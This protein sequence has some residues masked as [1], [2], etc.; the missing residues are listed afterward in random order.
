MAILSVKIAELVAK[1][2]HPP[3]PPPRD[4]RADRNRGRPEV[5]RPKGQ[6]V[7]K[8][9]GAQGKENADLQESL[10]EGLEGIV[11][12]AEAQQKEAELREGLLG[13]HAYEKPVEDENSQREDKA[14]NEDA[15]HDAQR[16]KAKEAAVKGQEK[17]QGAGNKKF[18]DQAKIRKDGFEQKAE[19]AHAKTKIDAP[20]MAGAPLLPKFQGGA[21]H[22]LNNAREPGGYFQE[23]GEGSGGAGG[24][25]E[26]QGDPELAA[27][28]EEAIR[29]LFGVRGIHRIGPGLSAEGEPVV[30]ISTTRGFSESSMRAV[31]ET[32][33]RFKTL[34][35]LPYEL[36]PLRRDAR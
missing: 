3:R 27:A 24:A 36:L 31:P 32:V 8:A 1:I 34:V 29:I 35:A 10:T 19:Q 25:P 16:V 28:V 15:H 17:D 2:I 6:R 11:T 4:T 30:V 9:S 14:R 13:L 22:V 33:H 21:M 23:V 12:L 7:N 5:Q 26:E 18:Q 20:A